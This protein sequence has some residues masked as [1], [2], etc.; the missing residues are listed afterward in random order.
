MPEIAADQGQVVGDGDGG[1]FEI[2]EGQ[3]GSLALEPGAETTADVSG[4]TVEGQD[5]DRRQENLLEIGQMKIG[6]RTF[7]GAIDNFGD[8]DGGD[9]LLPHRD[10]GETINQTRGRFL[11][12][13]MADA[14][15]IKEIHRVHHRRFAAT[16]PDRP[17]PPQPR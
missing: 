4:L 5:I 15:G 16:C 9:E 2:G 8:G 3:R 12:E 7:A 6:A 1:Y 11:L 13:E 10:G 14:V 17:T